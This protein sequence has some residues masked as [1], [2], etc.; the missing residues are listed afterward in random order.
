MIRCDFKKTEHLYKGYRLLG[1]QYRTHGGYVL[2]GR[3]FIE[4]GTKRNYL[5]VK[6]GMQYCK[7][8]IFERLKDAKRFIDEHLEIHKG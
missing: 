8:C 7:G 4:G 6:G 3:H 1:R 2:G 5:I